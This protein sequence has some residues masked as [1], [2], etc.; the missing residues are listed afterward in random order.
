M[1]MHIY[2]CIYENLKEVD[3]FHDSSKP[4]KLIQEMTN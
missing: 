4:P 3:N 1:C 2:I